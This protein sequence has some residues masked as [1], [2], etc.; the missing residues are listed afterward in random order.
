ML[1]RKVAWRDGDYRL[2]S[3]MQLSRD[4][5][6]EGFKFLLIR[7]RK[8]E[9]TGAKYDQSQPFLLEALLISYLSW[10]G[11]SDLWSKLCCIT[12]APV[13]SAPYILLCIVLKF[14]CLSLRRGSP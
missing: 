4:R 9:E 10:K 3:Q 8:E 5:D 11:F 2:L 13:A 14:V 12:L 1:V 6:S 7:E